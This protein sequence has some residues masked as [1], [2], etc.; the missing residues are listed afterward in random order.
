MAYNATP[1]TWDT[2][3][4]LIAGTGTLITT[5]SPKTINVE[6]T[7]AWGQQPVGLMSIDDDGL[8]M[9]PNSGGMHVSVLQQA[10]GPAFANDPRNWSLGRVPSSLDQVEFSSGRMN[11]L[12]GLRW[13]AEATGVFGVTIKCKGDF[14]PGQI[15]RLRGSLPDA[16]LNGDPLTYDE[17][18]D[19]VVRSVNLEACGMRITLGLSST[20]Q[21][22]R[23]ADVGFRVTVTLSQ[24]RFWR[25]FEGTI[26]RP[27]RRAD[28]SWETGNRYLR[29]TVIDQGTARNVIIGAGDQGAGSPRLM[30]NLLESPLDLVIR[31]SG[32][33]SGE[34][35]VQLLNQSA[36][37]EIEIL[38]GQL[39]VALGP[40]ELAELG[41]LRAYGGETFL[42]NV[43]CEAVLD[44]QST[45]HTSM[46]SVGGSKVKI[47]E[48]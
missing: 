40:T 29:A 18:T 1:A 4:E 12:Y 26:G 48:F 23:F 15:V 25:A 32:S 9:P 2:A 41:K 5:G 33:G 20:G 39:G 34:P 16:T 10:S 19:F 28:Q 8:K 17:E 24:L 42:G 6:F 13:D 7:G 43:D 44:Y 30:L 11:V 21:A 31:S 35:A 27:R 22:V 45:V 38:D 37:S 36:N 47:R 14:Q 46:V 3:L